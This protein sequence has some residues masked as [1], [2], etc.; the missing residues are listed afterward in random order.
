MSAEELEQR[1]K[2]LK[3]DTRIFKRLYFIRYR[4]EGDSVETAAEKVGVY[5]M[6]AYQW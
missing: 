1:I 6:V 5:K 4:Y 3:K 2:T